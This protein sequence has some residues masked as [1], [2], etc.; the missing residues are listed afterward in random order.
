MEQEAEKVNAENRPRR[1]RMLPSLIV[2]GGMMVLAL[3][4]LT[5]MEW[6]LALMLKGGGP[7]APENRSVER[8]AVQS[9][10]LQTYDEAATATLLQR[11]E[12]GFD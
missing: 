2:I 6:G 9:E 12:I 11:K 1:N 5:G 8:P 3:L 10:W 4:V 7:V